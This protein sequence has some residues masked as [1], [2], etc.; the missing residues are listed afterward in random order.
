MKAAAEFVENLQKDGKSDKV[1]R[2]IAETYGSLALT[3]QGH[4][5]FDAILLGL[6]GSLPH[7]VPLEDIPARLERIRNRHELHLNGRTISFEPEQDLLIHG[8]ELLPKH[9]NGMRFTAYD[10]EGKELAS[11][12]VLFHW[13]RFRGHR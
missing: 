7:S 2:I 12:D 13:R 9:P 11:Q 1:E 3:G 5:T 4:G 6:E 10:A 8:D